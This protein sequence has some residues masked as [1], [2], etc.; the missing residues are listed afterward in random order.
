MLVNSQIDLE[1]TDD[2]SKISLFIKHNSR[3][4]LKK[5][6]KKNHVL[7]VRDA[8]RKISN[9]I[10]IYVQLIFSVNNFKVIGQVKE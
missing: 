6:I 7:L 9:Q 4:E 1:S 5:F 2:K 10:D 3:V 8:T